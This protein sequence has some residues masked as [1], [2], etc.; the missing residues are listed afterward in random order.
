MEHVARAGI[1]DDDV[2]VAAR[3]DDA[4]AGVETVELGGIFAQRAA[5]AAERELVFIDGHSVDDLATRFDAGKTAG[6][7]R[8][9]VAAHVLLLERERA[10][11]GR[12]GL[13]LAAAQRLPERFTVLLR[14]DGRRADVA[15]GG[16]KVGIVVN[17]VVERQILR[18]GLDIH[19]LS[20]AARRGDLIK[21]S[22]VRRVDDDDGR[23][24]RLRDAQQT[25]NSLGL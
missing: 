8:K 22:T 2:G 24:G 5:D 16:G 13:H 1:V 14:A 15:R 4:L 3:S 6:D 9:V 17:A 12:D 20:A 18:A 25:R 7:L 11:V 23:V 10:V 21:R 19:G